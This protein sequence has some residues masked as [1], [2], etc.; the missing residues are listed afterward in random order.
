MILAGLLEGL[1]RRG[2]TLVATSN[3][4]PQELYKDGLQRAR[5]L[6]AIGLIERHVEVLQLDGG[7]DYRLRQLDAR[8]PI[9]TPRSRGTAAALQQ[10]SRRYAGAAGGAARSSA[11]TGARCQ[12][13]RAAAGM[14]WFE[15]ARAVRGRAQRRT[16]TS[17]S[18]G[19]YPTVFVANMPQFS[20]ARRGCGAAL[21]H[22][23]STSS[24]IAASSSWCRRAAP[25]GELY[26]GERLR[27]EFQR[28][29]SRLVEMQ[30]QQY[31]AGHTVLEAPRSPW[32]NSRMRTVAEFKIEYRQI[33]DP[34]GRLVATLPGF[35]ADPAK[36]CACTAR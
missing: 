6:P 34:N 35:A 29:A 22:A 11:S 27:F 5:F 13:R 1:F 18:R 32:H 8:Q 9:S 25:P 12:R 10:R 3:Q 33:L 7:I 17:S 4:P 20:A 24:T 36:C 19:R 28:A 31:L 15:F 2:V 21:H 14:A 30:T 26:R 16:T 23:R